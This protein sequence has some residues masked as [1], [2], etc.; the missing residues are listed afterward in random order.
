M[1]PQ[2]DV[3]T[4]SQ[5]FFS[6]DPA[7]IVSSSDHGCGQTFKASELGANNGSCLDAWW[8][9]TYLQFSRSSTKNKHPFW[10]LCNIILFEIEDFLF[11]KSLV[12]VCMYLCKHV[13]TY[14]CINL[15]EITKTHVPRRVLRQLQFFGN[16]LLLKSIVCFEYINVH[17]IFKN[18]T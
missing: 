4:F 11:W 17:H 5:W 13:C 16:I 12:V 9:R 2:A 6:L 7:V 10:P 3:M 8:E 14:K 1:P 18:Y 15:F